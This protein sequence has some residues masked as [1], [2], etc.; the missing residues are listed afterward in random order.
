MFLAVGAQLPKRAEITT[1]GPMPVLDAIDVLRNMELEQSTGLRGRVVVYGGGN[2]AMDVARSAIRLGAR[3]VTVIVVEA[4][5][6]MP[7]HAFEVRETLEEGAALVCLRAIRGVRVL[8][9]WRQ[10]RRR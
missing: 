10:V 3:E 6:Q 7:A 8:V 2:T 5:E 4:R 9:R 1:S